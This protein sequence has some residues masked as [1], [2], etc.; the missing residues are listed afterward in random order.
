MSQLKMAMNLSIHRTRAIGVV[1]FFGVCASAWPE[2]DI[3]S[4]KPLSELGVSD[5]RHPSAVR[6]SGL[7]SICWDNLNPRSV[8][9][10]NNERRAKALEVDREA[11]ILLV[12]ITM[13]VYQDKEID[14]QVLKECFEI[15]SQLRS[16]AAFTS[17]EFHNEYILARTSRKH[18]PRFL[19]AF[20]GKFAYGIESGVEKIVRKEWEL[21][22]KG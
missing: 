13:P 20:S 1:V 11:E 14:S 9:L 19:G 3:A 22:T 17:L 21:R 7:L 12:I 18:A 4:V 16:E 8:Q 2:P 6:L 15:L 10:P 5:P